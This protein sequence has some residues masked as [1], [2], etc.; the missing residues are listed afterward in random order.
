VCVQLGSI[1]SANIYR[2]DD[3]PLYKRGNSVL[4]AINVFVIFLFLGAK[5]YYV[6]KNNSR[7]KKWKALTPEVYILCFPGFLG[8]IT[9]YGMQQRID[10]TRNTTDLASRRLDFRFAH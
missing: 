4:L 7:D 8:S 3:K 9:D 10:Y 5:A 2:D 1:I 6:W